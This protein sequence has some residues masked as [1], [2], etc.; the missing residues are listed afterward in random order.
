VGRLAAEASSCG[1]G[2]AFDRAATRHN[3][4]DVVRRILASS[5][6]PI[7]NAGGELQSNDWKEESKLDA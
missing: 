5:S 2:M 4:I 1:V 3:A 6:A 7:R